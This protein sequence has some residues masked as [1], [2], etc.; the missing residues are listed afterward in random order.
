M[1][2][3]KF[4]AIAALISALPF[5]LQAQTE[6][7]QNNDPT[8]DVLAGQQEAMRMVPASTKLLQTID[9]NKIATGSVIKVKLAVKV[10]L[11]NGPELRP[12]TIL[13]GTVIKPNNGEPGG[14]RLAVRFTQADMKGG[15][16]IPIKATIVGVA[17]PTIG[18]SNE[19]GFPITPGEQSP[20]D[21]TSK[22]LRV[23]QINASSHVDMHSDIAS[24]DSGVFFSTANRDVKIPAGS[25]IKLAIAPSSG[26]TAAD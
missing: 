16:V 13:V 7:S 15:Q 25:E 4:L 11:E 10:H 14:S 5:S 24:D 17:K 20:N 2:T 1:K 9:A 22:T 23:E 6:V 3:S 12:G 8:G 18:F 19:N 26:T 21:W